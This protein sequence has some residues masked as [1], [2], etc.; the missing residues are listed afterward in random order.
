MTRWPIVVLVIITA[1]WTSCTEPA[2]A[3]S[4]QILQV[5]TKTR[6]KYDFP[7]LAALVIKDGKID[8]VAAVGV[9]KF[10]DLT[11]L[12]TNDVFHIGSCTKSMTATV[13]ASLIEQGM[14]KWNTTIGEVFPE[15]KKQMNGQYQDVTLQQLLTHR[16]GVPAAPPAAAWKRARQ[17]HGTLRQQRYEFIKSVLAEPPEVAPGTKYVYSNQGYAIAGAMLERITGVAY[18]Q[19]MTNRLFKPLHMDSAGFG[20][21]GTEGKVDQPWG[22][23]RDGS[24]I[25]AL[26]QDNPQAIAPA[27]T[28]HCTL[29]D[30]ARYAICHLHGEQSGAFLK[31][32]TFRH[33]HTPAPGGDYACGWICAERD[34]A[35]GTALTHSGSNTMWYVVI[36]LAPAKDFGVIVGT[37]TGASEAFKGCDEVAGTLI[38]EWRT[39][40]R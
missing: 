21:P 11:R 9:R 33:L 30:L 24:K 32:E 6:E 4:A 38:R 28:L 1:I 13:A 26:Q 36:W 10:G 19:L 7:G 8:S 3:D 25:V 31:P 39:G 16:G 22:H 23:L 40:S 14:L 27:G 35:G 18:E 29:T 20:P 34:W 37:N 5:L 12:T 15:L 2:F 17:G